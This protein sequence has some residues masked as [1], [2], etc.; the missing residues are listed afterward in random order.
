MGARQVEAFLT[1]ISDKDRVSLSTQKVA[2]CAIVFLDKQVLQID[3][4]DMSFLRAK[5][6]DQRHPIRL[7]GPMRIR[8]RQGQSVRRSQ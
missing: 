3:L 4:G 7:V 2:L 1:H 8:C 6:G 5:Q